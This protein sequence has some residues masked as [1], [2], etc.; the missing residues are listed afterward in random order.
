MFEVTLFFNNEF[1]IA[2]E[3]PPD[4]RDGIEPMSS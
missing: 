2:K 4:T 3:V 1:Y